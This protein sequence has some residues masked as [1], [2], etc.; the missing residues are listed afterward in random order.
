MLE[1]PDLPDE[2]ISACLLAE[3]GLR[4]TRLEF[5]PLGA[6]RN[7]AVYQA[8]TEDSAR[9][10]VK[11]RQGV[12]DEVSVELP[13]FL[14]GQG[15][16]QVIAPVTGNSGQLW[17]SLE[18]FKVI[19][20]PFVEGRDGYQREMTEGNWHEFGS[21]MRMLHSITLPPALGSQLQ[22]ETY[23]AEWREKL[24]AFLRQKNNRATA[25]P[26][27]AKLATFLNARQAG[28]SAL[29]A[30]TDQLAHA[31]SDQPLEFVACHADI[32]PGN[33][34]LGDDQA[35]HIVD[36][37]TVMLAPK[38][39]DLMFIGG[40]MGFHCQTAQ[41]E[42]DLFYRGYGPT[43]IHPGALAYYRHARVIE[44]MAVEC[45]LIF[46]SQAGREDREREF[47]YFTSNFLPGGTI[48][49]ARKS[50]QP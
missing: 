5:L 12:F 34:L 9:W 41:E 13:K 47:R 25:D 17:A 33:L 19:L 6:D 27:A 21:A 32:H 3:F 10:F 16:R 35:F 44:D 46:S 18:A 31:L 42:L 4:V 28:I 24:R 45:E 14:S 1:K 43:Q 26:I 36:W 40:G 49:I 30:R 11:L 50:D 29:I 7:S 22:R 20:Y 8:V 2:K 48:E 38:E 15:L 23:S 37:D 39:R